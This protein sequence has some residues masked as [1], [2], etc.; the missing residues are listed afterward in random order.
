MAMPVIPK[1]PDRGP[2]FGGKAFIIFRPLNIAAAGARGTDLEAKG[3]KRT[4][5][6]RKPPKA[7][8]KRTTP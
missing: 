3:A 7:P 6:S 4:R 2:L 5:C 1:P 8:R